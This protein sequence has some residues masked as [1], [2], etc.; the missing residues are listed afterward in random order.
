M[1]GQISECPVDQ[2][3]F[4]NQIDNVVRSLPSKGAT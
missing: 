4:I 2:P 3:Q 1:G